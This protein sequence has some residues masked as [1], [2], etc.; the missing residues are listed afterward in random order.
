MQADKL[1]TFACTGKRDFTGFSVHNEIFAGAGR[2]EQGA[3]LFSSRAIHILIGHVNHLW[4]SKKSFRRV[5][6]VRPI[7][8]GISGR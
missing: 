1:A 5:W 4:T 8:W 7:T 3:N 6:C 2:A